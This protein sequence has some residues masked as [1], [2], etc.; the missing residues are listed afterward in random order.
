MTTR[1]SVKINGKRFRDVY[2]DTYNAMRRLAS[3]YRTGTDP[4]FL[5][6]RFQC[7]EFLIRKALAAFPDTEERGGE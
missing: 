3:D 2:K 7:S 4:Y 5:C 1:K 6:E